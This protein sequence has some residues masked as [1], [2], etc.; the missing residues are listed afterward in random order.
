MLRGRAGH[1]R[2]NGYQ[3]CGAA[4]QVHGVSCGEAPKALCL[5]AAARE[6]PEVDGR[7][8]SRHGRN[9][10]HRCASLV[11]ALCSLWACSPVNQ[12]ELSAQ[13]LPPCMCLQGTGL[14]FGCGCVCPRAA[15]RRAAAPLEG[16]KCTQN[17]LALPAVAEPEQTE[18][19]SHRFVCLKTS[20]V[21]TSLFYRNTPAPSRAAAANPEPHS[22]TTCPSSCS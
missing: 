21:A 5:P 2:R 6:G 8:R 18:T 11:N 1:A 15:P 14:A 7:R 13:L 12:Q 9:R 16:F 4:T 17:S 10:L 22:K 3:R 19:V 20:L